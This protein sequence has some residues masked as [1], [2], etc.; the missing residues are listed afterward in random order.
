MR[1]MVFGYI[2]NNNTTIIKY[3]DIKKYYFVRTQD[4]NI[5]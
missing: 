1:D 4:G 5:N 3:V 2:F